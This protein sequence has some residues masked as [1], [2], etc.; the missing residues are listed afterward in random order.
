MDNDDPNMLHKQL[1]AYIHDSSSNHSAKT[2][3][4]QNYALI[5]VY[6]E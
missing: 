4:R 1:R 6:I 2:N 5:L 3:M